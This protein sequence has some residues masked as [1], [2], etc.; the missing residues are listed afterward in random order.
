[1]IKNFNISKNNIAEYSFLG[2]VAVLPFEDIFGSIMLVVTITLALLFN[3]QKKILNVLKQNQILWFLMAY[4][5]IALISLVY[6]QDF[7]ESLKKL[8]KLLAFVLIPLMFVS[9]NPCQK[10]IKSGKKVFVYAML[11]FSIFS[12]LKLGYNYIVNHD[13]SHWYNFVQDSMYHKYMPEDAMYLN[14]ALILLLFGDFK[15][16]LK[17][18]AAILFLIV[19][20]LFSVRLGLFLYLSIITIYFSLNIKSLLT[21][22]SLI[23]VALTVSVSLLLV[24]Q[25][26][27]AND[28]FYDTLDKIGF[29]TGNQVSEI[30]SKYHK[31]GLREK[32]WSTSIELIAD[33]PILGQG[34][35]VE[36]RPLA[37]KNQKKEYDIPSNYHSHN[38][39]LSSMVQYGVFG[40]TWLLGIFAFLFWVTI[41]NKNTVGILIVVVMIISMITESYLEL[42]QGVFYF[43][44]FTSLLIW[45]LV[46]KKKI[47][48][49]K[50][51]KI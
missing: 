10:L 25:S 1:M 9:L 28:K 11:A 23:I 38:Q 5:G 46:F 22:K 41:K 36:K 2:F 7:P 45:K 18:F 20:V 21:W 47:K 13:I 49:L 12:L 6:S 14:T 29:N 3:P 24:N 35:G 16:N 50:N 43:C 51:C 48:T 30:G 4:Y 19:I 17:L 40:I 26:R 32:I 33:R 37:V 34:A 39:F 15:K 31:M 42:Q 27:Y 44:F 8:S